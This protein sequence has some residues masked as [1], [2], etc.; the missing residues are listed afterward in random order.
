MDDLLHVDEAALAA[1]KEGKARRPS[2]ALANAA[3][4]LRRLSAMDE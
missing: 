3:S 4:P 2:S 1:V